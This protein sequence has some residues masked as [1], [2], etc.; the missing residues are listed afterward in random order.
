MFDTLRIELLDRNTLEIKNYATLASNLLREDRLSTR[1]SEFLPSRIGEVKAERNDIV[2]LVNLADNSQ[3]YLGVI[4]VIAVDRETD[5]AKITSDTFDRF[6]DRAVRVPETFSG[7]I[8]DLFITLVTDNFISSAD[9][10]ANVAYFQFNKITN[11]TVSI[12]FDSVNVNLR[13]ILEEWFRI[14][15]LNITY[16]LDRNLKTITINISTSNTSKTLKLDITDVRDLSIEL[17]NQDITNRVDLYPSPENVID[18]TQE[19]YYLLS[20]DTITQNENDPNRLSPVRNAIIEYQ[21]GDNLQDIA[22]QN[23]VSNIYNHLIQFGLKEDSKNLL[24]LIDV[25]I[26]DRV[27]LIDKDATYESVLTGYEIRSRTKY[28]KLIF[29]MVRLN[30]TDKLRRS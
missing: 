24:P 2:H 20:D 27:T 1:L 8:E 9:P 29:G 11:T 14:F 17:S 15:Q 16:T 25:K 10:L 13:D 30:L 28:I 4:E 5:I 26:N 19:T 22:E 23:L 21:D 18:L 12:K 6:F 3:I 7:F